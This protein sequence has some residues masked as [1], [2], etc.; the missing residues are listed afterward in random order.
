METPI[1]EL[2]N[3][4]KKFRKRLIL[5]DVNLKIEKN[6][7][8]GF[9]GPNGSG[10][11]VTFKII[12]GFMNVTSGKVIVNGA[13]VR[14][15]VMFA[16]GIGFS[17]QEYG[18]LKDKTGYENLKLLTLLNKNEDVDIDQLLNDVGLQKGKHLKVN[19]Y[20]LG[21]NQRLLIAAA[22]IQNDDILIFD[23]P[24]NA[25]DENGLAFLAKL[26]DDLKQQGKTVLVSSHDYAFL[27]KIADNIF[28]YSSEGAITEE[29]NR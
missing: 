11:S 20:S 15:D 24:T 10:K 21:M 17:M 16:P 18:L 12:L 4:S 28:K 1:I 13:I 8:Y 29:V 25:L 3:V 9:S 14:K 2:I 27:A 23:E 7:V 5:D 6:K 22:L 26:I 19:E